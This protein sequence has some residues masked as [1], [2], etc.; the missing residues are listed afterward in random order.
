M[1]DRLSGLRPSRP[2]RDSLR[3]L[4]ERVSGLHPGSERADGDDVAADDVAADD[5]ARTDGDSMT[6]GDAG[7]RRV[8]RLVPDLIARSY[9]TK[10]LVVLLLVV[11]AIGGVGVVTYAETTNHL[12]QDAQED[13]VAVA[14]LGASN[15]DRWINERRDDVRGTADASLLDREV[16]SSDDAYPFEQQPDVI[17]GY[18]SSRAVVTPD[19]MAG[20]H[21]I[22]RDTGEVV[23]SGTDE[24]GE[25]LS[26]MG[27]FDDGVSFSDG[28]AIGPVYEVDGEQRVAFV[29]ETPGRDFLVMEFTFE[30]V[31]SE[32]RT[33][34]EGSFTTIVDRNGDIGASDSDD[35]AG[36]SYDSEEWSELRV[37]LDSLGHEAESTLGDE[38]YFVA[39]APVDGEDWLVA[40]HVPTD[41]AYALA[42][43]IARNLLV[44]IGVAVVGLG[45]LG[46]TLGRGTVQELNRLGARARELEAGQLDVDL[47]THRRDELGQLYGSFDA[48]RDSLRDQIAA[49]ETQRERAEA[50]KAE[51]EATA[52]RLQMRAEAFG[53]TMGECAEG[54]LTARLEADPEDP[55]ALH[56]VADAFNDAMAELE[57][58]VARVDAFADD[59]A[60]AS[61]AVTSGTEEVAAAGR[62]TSEAVDEI[63]AGAERQSRQLS[64][65]AGETEDMSATIQEVAASADQVAA[66]SRRADEL[67]DEGREAAA[68][69]VEELH[70]IED[71]SESAAETVER[72]EAEMEEVD[73]IVETISEIAEQTN[74]LALNA[75][76]EAARAGEAGSGFAVVAD[77]VKSLAEETQSSAAEVE[78]LITDLRERT[79]ESVEE[80]DA[81][82]DGVDAGVVTGEAAEDALADIAERVTEADEGVQEISGAMDAQAASVN[83]VA[84]AVD[85]LAGIS[86][87]TTAEATSVAATAEEQAVTLDDVSDRAEDL[88][89]R[90]DE[91]RTAVDRFEVD[92]DASVDD[93]AAEG[94]DDDGSEDAE[95]PVETESPAGSEGAADAAEPDDDPAGFEFGND[96]TDVDADSPAVTDGSGAELEGTDDGTGATSGSVASDDEE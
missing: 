40:V 38:E 34:T 65:V 95:P 19:S 29:G 48:M 25:H 53:E 80:M 16:V 18:L 57:T 84:G 14:E 58:T 20:I 54:D 88:S 37:G 59:V 33:P 21:L 91:L 55:D 49:A 30:D 61:G 43:D 75:S 13:Y 42:G 26:E 96:M 6:N 4:R 87:Q 66:T 64:E 44:I 22:N 35:A 78:S 1:R 92:V 68:E 76:I 52:E 41:E 11:A 32:F 86:Q 70:T 71:R 85:E 94:V 2:D 63:S 51:S 5:E 79:D 8:A 15:L 24:S 50:A 74:L 81:I 3:A 12:E 89:A 28:S 36:A 31:T 62:E 73:A 45:L 72:L 56:E 77:E 23:V 9:L 17:A 27:W 46:M 47:E 93:G 82:R 83:D 10:F 90:A 60:T 69:A 67:T 39:Y 7:G